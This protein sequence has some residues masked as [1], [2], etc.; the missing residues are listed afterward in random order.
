MSRWKVYKDHED[1]WL[2]WIAQP[3]NARWWEEAQGRRFPQWD[4]ALRYA[5]R[6]AHHPLPRPAWNGKAVA[7]ALQALGFT[8]EEQA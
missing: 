2:R 4:M 6:M 7:E 5:A 3:I 8:Q 1:R